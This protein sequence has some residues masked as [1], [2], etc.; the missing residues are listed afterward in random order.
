M[1][2]VSIISDVKVFIRKCLIRLNY[3]DFFHV[4]SVYSRLV[5][6]A[7]KHCLI[8]SSYVFCSVADSKKR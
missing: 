4:Q 7:P 5:Y 1:F 3:W 6:I 2:S 8:F